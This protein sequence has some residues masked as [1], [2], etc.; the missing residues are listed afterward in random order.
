MFRGLRISTSLLACLPLCIMLGGSPSPV[1]GA[2]PTPGGSIV[3]AHCGD[4]VSFGVGE[5]A[6][7]R[8]ENLS[9][10]SSSLVRIG[11]GGQT[12]TV[13]VSTN[14]PYVRGVENK[15]VK[16]RLL[17]SGSGGP[18]RGEVENDCKSAPR[19]SDVRVRI[20][21]TANNIQK[22]HV[23]TAGTCPACGCSLQPQAQ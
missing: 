12:E 23:E 13:S 1:L 11:I 16:V 20:P 15:F 8:I 9:K 4:W 10:S 18:C 19:D 3:L 2:E 21:Y 5:F 22:C 7:V 6:E 14:S 17:E